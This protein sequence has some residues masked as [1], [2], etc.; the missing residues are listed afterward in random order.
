MNATKADFGRLN[1]VTLLIKKNARNRP[2]RIIFFIKKA[3]MIMS[4][5]YLNRQ[6]HLTLFGSIG[7]STKKTR[8][9]HQRFQVYPPM[10]V[11]IGGFGRCLDRDK[12]KQWGHT[13]EMGGCGVIPQKWGEG[14]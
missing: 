7:T 6:E 5:D 10:S 11:W 3:T 14:R 2:N 13:M 8:L 9:A 4:T 12:K 1:P